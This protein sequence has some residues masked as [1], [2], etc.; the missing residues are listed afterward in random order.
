MNSLGDSKGREWSKSGR[1][2]ANVKFPKVAEAIPSGIA[3]SS[4]NEAR[5]TVQFDDSR[6]MA[7]NILFKDVQR[8]KDARATRAFAVSG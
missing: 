6:G 3:I 1:K 2:A 7:C 4:L 5:G 8:L